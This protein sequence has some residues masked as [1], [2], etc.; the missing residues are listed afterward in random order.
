M[1]RID[2]Q[3]ARRN[4]A[5][6]F[7][8]QICLVALFVIPVLV[9]FYRDEIGLGFRE[10]IIGEALFSL[11]MILME[12]PSGYLSDI[13]TRR[14]VLM[15]AAFVH[16][17][18]F[19]TLLTASTFL[20]TL[21]AQAMLGV[22][23]SLFSGTPSA[24]LYDSLIILRKRNLFTRLEGRRHAFGLYSVALCGI[25]GGFLY[26]INPALP[27]FLTMVGSMGALICACLIVEPP[28]V[29][30]SVQ[31]HPLADMRDTMMYAL[32]GHKEIAGI[33]LMA[34]SLFAAT[35]CMLWAQQPY[36]IGLGIGESWFGVLMAVGAIMGGAGGQLSHHAEHIATPV[37]RLAVLYV[38]V[39]MAIITA[40]VV[41]HPLAIP[42]LM[43]GSMIYGF[44]NPQ[45]QA[46]IN[47]RVGSARRATIL[48]TQNLV[49]HVFAMPL[50]VMLGQVSGFYDIR[51]ALIVLA[52]ILGVV[53][54]GALVLLRGRMRR[55]A[56]V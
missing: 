35:K 53:G 34:A 44:A 1:S 31:A 3:D 11:V 32:R 8:Y 6:L 38:V 24:L 51:V 43:A 49:M 15:L 4:I 56:R 10:F 20:D 54:A 29:K 23:I 16:L 46:A 2:L 30:Q 26:A 27:I 41:Y 50:Y 22:A 42:L 5:L 48:S 45:V 25:V 14:R 37:K 55:T 18:G 39:I 12:V 21:I 40:A 7:L 19:F 28:R 36:Y 33:I 13:W 17:A 9:P 47:R 52:S